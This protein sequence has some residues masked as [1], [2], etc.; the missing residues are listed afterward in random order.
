MSVLSYPFHSFTLKLSYKG[1]YFLFLPLELPN[2]T[3]KEYSKIILINFH[4][5]FHSLCQVLK[6]QNNWQIVNANLFRYRSQSLYVLLD[7]AQGD[8]SQDSRTYKLQKEEFRICL[9][10][11]IE[12][13]A[14]FIESRICKI[15][16][17][18]KQQRKPIKNQGFRSTSPSI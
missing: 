5:F 8:S 10:K 15:L 1:M 9:V 12:R 18:P 4:L 7:N 16:I 6:V 14:R 2:K 17:K 11:P 13:Q 3:R